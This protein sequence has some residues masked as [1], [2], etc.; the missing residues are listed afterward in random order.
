MT[1]QEAEA[2][3]KRH[4]GNKTAAAREAGLSRGAFKRRLA[5]VA[6]VGVPAAVKG[7]RSLADFRA[8]YD[9]GYIVP[10]KIKAALKALGSGWEYEVAFAKLCGVSLA[11]LGTFRDAFAA[12]HV[13]TLSDHRRAWAG[14]AATAKAMREML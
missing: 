3:L 5:G 1:K 12:S 6:G 9:K 2:L 4:G 10:Q 7:G 14:T 11:D 13:V 8:A